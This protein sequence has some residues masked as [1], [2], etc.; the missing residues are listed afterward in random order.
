[1]RSITNMTHPKLLIRLAFLLLLMVT[2]CSNPEI[3]QYH[4][5]KNRSWNR[6]DKVKFTIPIQKSGKTYDVLFFAGVS[7][8]YE[9]DNLDFNMVMTSPSGE[10]RIKEYKFP[11][12]NKQGGF[13]GSCNNDSCSNSLFLK[14]G[15]MVE[16]G[17]ILTIE[18]EPL[19]PRVQIDE[20]LGIGIR[21]IETGK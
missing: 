3:V 8:N 13:L 20:V 21:V 2:S 6:F 14:K 9:Y 19:V 18:I 12:R 16:K 4:G 17:G 1:M 5:F 10:E 11:V 7:R 15:L